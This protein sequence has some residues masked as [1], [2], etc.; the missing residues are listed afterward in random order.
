MASYRPQCRSNSVS[1]YGEQE[2][3]REAVAFLQEPWRY[4]HPA[5]ADT[6]GRCERGR[7][8]A[9]NHIIGDSLGL[10]GGGAP[11]ALSAASLGLDGN[12]AGPERGNEHLAIAEPA[13]VLD[14]THGAVYEASDLHIVIGRSPVNTGGSRV[15]H[16]SPRPR[17]S[18][19]L[20][21]APQDPARAMTNGSDADG[22]AVSAFTRMRLQQGR[23]EWPGVQEC[24]WGSGPRG[25]E[26]PMPWASAW[27]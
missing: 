26:M 4:T 27:V 5:Q 20:R 3:L 9:R 22:R 13:C 18:A 2:R 8:G 7:P 12:H 16:A 24:G 15:G 21:L 25:A 10:A 19:A 11:C 14:I 1:H 17:R 6:V 23:G